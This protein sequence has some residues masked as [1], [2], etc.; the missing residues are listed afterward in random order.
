MDMKTVMT[1][2][3]KV[4]MNVFTIMEMSMLIVI[5]VM[6]VMITQGTALSGIVKNKKTLDRKVF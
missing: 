4:V 6:I 1:A 3:Q 2:I 5:N